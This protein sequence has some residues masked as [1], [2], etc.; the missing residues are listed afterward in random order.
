MTVPI[1]VGIAQST[2]S[3]AVANLQDSTVFNPSLI[4]G[5]PNSDIA[6]EFATDQAS[7]QLG[8]SSAEATGLGDSGGRSTGAPTLGGGGSASDLTLYLQIAGLAAGAW[9]LLKKKKG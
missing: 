4:I 6:S 8:S 5:S 9:F 1:T 2:S 7:K 3:N